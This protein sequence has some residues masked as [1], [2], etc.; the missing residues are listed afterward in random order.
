MK[1]LLLSPAREA[2]VY[3][4][5]GILIPQLALF[6]LQGLTPEKHKITILEEEFKPIDFDA[7][8]DLIAISCMTSNA[9]RGYMIAG[10]FKKRGK[11]VVMGGIH[12]TL[13]PDEALQYCDS[14]VIGEAEGVWET[15]L[16]DIEQNQLKRTYHVTD[17]DLTRYIPKDY[18]A[19]SKS[20]FF[21]LVPIM[22][23]RG[24]PYDCDFCCVSD[25]FGKKIKHMPIENVVRDIVESKA[26]RF[27]FLDDNIIGN[28]KYAR[29]LFNALK[30]LKITWIGQASISFANDLEMMALA[31]K[32]GCVGLFI[33]LESVVESRNKNLRKLS[34]N[35][36]DTEESLKKIRKM[37]II[38]MASV[39]FGF[40]EDTP[41][42]FD[43]TVDFLIKNKISIGSLNILTPYPGTKTFKDL[44][45]QNRLINER[46]E[47]YDHHTVVYQPKNMSPM[48]LQI[49][50][51]KAKAKFYT[52]A[53]IMKRLFANSFSPVIYIASNLGYRKLARQEFKRIKELESSSPDQGDNNV[54]LDSMIDKEE[55]IME[56]AD[57]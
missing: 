3:S 42:I 32:S 2:H 40:D 10:E 35:L 6:I 38:I 53:S 11:T 27:I 36:K 43:D 44:K 8:Y 55:K 5:K 31:R 26:K 50:K 23:T 46:W 16:E 29:E 20:Q 1:I 37:G 49:G 54:F 41:E 39:I 4:N 22:T 7:D 17:P 25:I 57:M 21:N 34:D 12:P 33:G 19:I 56:N 9:K 28:R 48:E 14:V 24:C 51:I 30:P 45:A 15:L 47:H 52:L 13:L 18:S